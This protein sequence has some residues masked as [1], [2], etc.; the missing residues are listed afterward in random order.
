MTTTE[1]YFATEGNQSKKLETPVY[2]LE[3]LKA[4]MKI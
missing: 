2:D 3:D 4:G 1:V